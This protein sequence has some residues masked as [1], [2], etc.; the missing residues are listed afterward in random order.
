VGTSP[1][2]P[3]KEHREARTATVADVIDEMDVQLRSR[4][5]ADVRTV[6][7]G[8]EV[9]DELLAGGL[10]AGELILLGGPPGVGKTITALQ[11]AR[12]VARDG[13]RVLYVC[14]EHEPATLLVRLLALEAAEASGGEAVGRTLIEALESAESAGQPLEQTLQALPGGAQALAQVRSYAQRLMIVRASGSHT[15]VDQIRSSVAAHSDP[16]TNT[17]VFVDYL[18]KIPVHPE[19]DYESEKVTRTVEGLKDLALELHVPVVVISAVH[20]TGL[21]VNRIRLHHLRGSS[22]VAFEADVVLMLNDKH[23][24]VSKVHL[25]YDTRAARTFRDWVV[26]SLEK[27][28]GGPNLVDLEFRK[29][30]AHFRFDP[31]GG[32]VSEQLVNERLDEDAL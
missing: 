18:Q 25:S 10:S 16:E 27:N 6:P 8:W 28:R 32:L 11:W 24:A 7:T 4:T 15:T 31:S 29:D 3:S 20:Q 14:F 21:D 9:L 22:A 30:F 2:T 17:V 12:N 23:K 19:P 26:F 13:H 5:A 1:S